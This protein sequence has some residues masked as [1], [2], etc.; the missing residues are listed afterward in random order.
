MTLAV[1]PGPESEKTKADFWLCYLDLG[2]E[3][4]HKLQFL[5]LLLGSKRT[6]TTNK[7]TKTKVPHPIQLFVQVK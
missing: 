7:Q 4:V 2:L 1:G 6:P 3:T 5:F